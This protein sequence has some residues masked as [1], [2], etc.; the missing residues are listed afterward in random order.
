[1]SA[2]IPPPPSLGDR[3][4]VERTALANE[5]TLLAWLRTALGLLAGSVTL[6]QLE[7]TPARWTLAAALAALGVVAT[8]VGAWR[9]RAADRRMRAL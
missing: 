7:P 2:E 6:L 4:A 1:M 5:R 3:L 8:A 9:Y